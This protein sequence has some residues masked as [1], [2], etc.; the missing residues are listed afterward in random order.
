MPG[1]TVY[2]HVHK[3]DRYLIIEKAICKIRWTDPLAWIKSNTPKICGAKCK[4][5]ARLDGD[6]KS[7]CIV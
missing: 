2:K 3:I 1:L 7:L 6:K 4:Q 5:Y